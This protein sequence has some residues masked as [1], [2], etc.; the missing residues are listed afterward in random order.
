MEMSALDEGGLRG[1]LWAVFRGHG[2]D[3][4]APAD[5]SANLAPTGIGCKAISDTFKSIYTE[6]AL[7]RPDTG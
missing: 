4:D 7:S 2:D 6:P 5:R 3:R 1:G